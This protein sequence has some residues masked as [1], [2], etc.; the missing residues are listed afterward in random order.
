MKLNTPKELLGKVV[1]IGKNF[2]K[3]VNQNKEALTLVLLMASA[4]IAR[5]QSDTITY[6]LPGDGTLVK[7]GVVVDAHAELDTLPYDTAWKFVKTGGNATIYG[8][9]TD[10]DIKSN[11]ACTA[12]T[13]DPIVS[14]K[15]EQAS[16]DIAGFRLEDGNYNEIVDMMVFLA[17]Q[18]TPLDLISFSAKVDTDT[19][20][21]DWATVNMINVAKTEVQISSDGGEDYTTI[22]SEEYKKDH[23]E[24]LNHK[25][26]KAI[27]DIMKQLKASGEYK[28][29][30]EDYLLRLKT[31][32]NDGSS[33]KSKMIQ[34][35]IDSKTGKLSFNIVPNPASSNSHIDLR[36]TNAEKKDVRSIE[37][38]NLIGKR[39]L[40]FDNID[41]VN[42]NGLRSGTYLI[43]ITTKNGKQIT[44]KLQ[45]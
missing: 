43:K 26:K 12:D 9:S 8:S 45:I 36:L 2:F 17:N 11:D 13:N 27:D 10:C 30:Q 44:K 40:H 37:I 39:V 5:G 3:V 19:L 34:I 21:I 32:D 16:N 24:K 38:Y 41:A 29:G 25:Q 31:T 20:E 33:E 1:K 18:S 4:G 6:E 14:K 7:N 28:E 23:R 35:H 22:A 15:N 42:T